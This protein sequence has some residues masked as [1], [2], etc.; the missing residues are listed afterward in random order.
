MYYFDYI[1]V[2]LCFE[3]DGVSLFDFFWLFVGYKEL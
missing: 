1:V 2:S 3:C